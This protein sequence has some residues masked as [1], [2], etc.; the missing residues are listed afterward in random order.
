MAESMQAQI[1]RLEKKL[2]EYA[3]K[4][5][6][7]A[8]ASAINKVAGPVRT[9]VGRKVAAIEKLPTRLIAKQMF[10]NKASAK[11]ITAVIKSYARGINAARLLSGSVIAK[12]MGTGTSR[13]GVTVK[14]RVYPGAFINRVKRGKKQVL[15]FTRKGAER[16]PLEVAR[17]DISQHLKREQ[18]PTARAR[19]QERFSKFYL[20]ELNYRVGKYVK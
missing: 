17:I 13:A 18:L 19:Y 10:F 6:V 16:L 7:Q 1:K 3:N 11:N 15:V 20:Q 2:K 9:E 5:A 8:A 4:H 14:G 12:K